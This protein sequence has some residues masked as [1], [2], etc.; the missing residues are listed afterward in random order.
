MVR[1][2]D[3]GFSH[4]GSIPISHINIYKIVYSLMVKRIAHDDHDVGSNPARLI[5]INIKCIIIFT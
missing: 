2:L 4:M 3:C 1:M 5:F